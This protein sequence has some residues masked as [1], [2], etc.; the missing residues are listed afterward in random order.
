VTRRPLADVPAPLSV[1]ASLAAVEGLILMLF[2]V[3]E[4][5]AFTGTR[6]AMGA[7]TA[8][9]FL[10]YGAVLIGCGWAMVRGRSWARSPVVLGQ[11][12]QMGIAWSF[13][14]GET[15]LVAVG[16]AIV[17]VVVLVG[18]FHPASIAH[19]SDEPAP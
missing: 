11:L 3:L 4:V 9:F 15:T 16:L 7:T 5:A 13:R 19:L 12:I 14:G 6:A 8:A 18:I 17:A 2:G 1:A 10:A